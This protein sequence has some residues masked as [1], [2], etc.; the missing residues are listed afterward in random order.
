MIDRYTLRYFLAVVD[1]GNF[2]KAAAHCSVSQPTLSVG[3]AKLE[4]ELGQPLFHR[5]NR[6][7]E[8]TPAGARFAIHA[9]RIEAEFALAEHAVHETVPRTMLRLGVLVTIP[10][11]WIEAFIERLRPDLGSEPVEIVEGRERD[12]TE[13]LARGRLDAALTIVRP[14]RERFA[15]ETLFSEGYSLAMSSRHELAGRRLIAAE[16]LADNRMIVRRQCELLSD[17]SR[18]FTA[19]GVRPFFPARTLSDERAL[20]YVRT[21]LGVTVMPDCFGGEGIVRPKLEDFPFTRDIG[22]LYGNHVDPAR[23]RHEHAISTLIS[24]LEASH[25]APP[26]GPSDP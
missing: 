13:R 18:Y 3:I 26:G 9:R 24:S 22:L 11:Q 21:G 4:R 14:D 8:L 23:L 7:V 6:R 2:S 15:S 5:T 10:A 12:L 19:R 17:T 16:E 20:G 25:A 1:T